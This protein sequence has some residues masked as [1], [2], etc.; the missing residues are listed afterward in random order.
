[1]GR[2]LRGGTLLAC[3]RSGKGGASCPARR[4]CP[5]LGL[6]EQPVVWLPGLPGLPLEACPSQIPSGPCREM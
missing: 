6:P 2:R 1:M 3:R 5:R 4:S